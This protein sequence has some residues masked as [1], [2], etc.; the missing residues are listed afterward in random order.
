MSRLPAVWQ[1]DPGR[2]LSGS[3]QIRASKVR[4]FDATFQNATTRVVDS[5]AIDR[6]R[7]SARDAQKFDLEQVLPD[8]SVTLI[9]EAENLD[10]AEVDCLAAALRRIAES[11]VAIGGKKNRGS[12]YV[13][14]SSDQCKMYTRKLH[15]ANTLLKAV[16]GSGN[17]GWKEEFKS[18]NAFK[19][20]ASQA[21]LVAETTL[22]AVA[23]S[24]LLINDP[25]RAAASG[26]DRAQR[27]L[28]QA[29]EMPP[30]SLIGA[31]R[32]GAERIVRSMG[33][34]ACAAEPNTAC[35]QNNSCVVCQLFGNTSRASR[36]SVK[37]LSNHASSLLAV[38]HVAIDRFTGGARDGKKFDALAATNTTFDVSFNIND[39]EQDRARAYAGLLTLV[40]NEL[41]LGRLSIGSGGAK[42]SGYFSVRV[43]QWHV[44]DGWDA[45]N[46]KAIPACLKAL[47]SLLASGLNAEA[48]QR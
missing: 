15:D 46:D 23:D 47:E 34:F 18:L 1:C 27:M 41:H 3:A 22:T 7:R 12:G 14:G 30:A 5:V 38:D 11:H 33:G 25:T 2:D 44:P 45:I 48:P 24:P 13:V 40:L 31:I 17:D 28:G 8:A 36:L 42:G 29:A 9:V 37:V 32:S 19:Q 39:M 43:P 20:L 35:D 6:K 10:S 21:A 16:L 4:V 26:F